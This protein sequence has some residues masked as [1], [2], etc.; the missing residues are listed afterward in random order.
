MAKRKHT[1]QEAM[2]KLRQAE[3]AISEG[4]TAAEA[5]RMIGVSKQTLYRWRARYQGWSIDQARRL[6]QL[7][8]ENA[9]LQ[10][11][12]ERLSRH[13]DALQQVAKSKLV[14]PA[15]RRHCV[16]R[17]RAVFGVSERRACRVLGQHRSTQRRQPTT[18]SKPSD[19]SRQAATT[20][21]QTNG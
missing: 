19:H 6:M 10:R 9:R 1:P 5:S 21:S 16:E 11:E 13:N 15:R 2:S 20:P 14:S 4:S 12:L 8:T 7:Q 17:V 3:A 18:V